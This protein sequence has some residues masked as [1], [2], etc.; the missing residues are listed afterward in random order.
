[1]TKS[2]I[3]IPS[4]TCYALLVSLESVIGKVG[5]TAVLRYAG[6][7]EFIDNYPPN[8]PD[9]TC[10]IADVSAIH[11]GIETLY[12]WRGGKALIMNAGRETWKKSIDAML[13]SP[14]KDI[15]EGIQQAPQEERLPRILNF[16]AR[17]FNPSND[18]KVE[19]VE[20]DDACIYVN[21]FCVCCWG[22]K[23]TKA[24]CHLTAGYLQEAVRWATGM[25]YPVDQ[26]TC[27]GCGDESCNYS[28]SKNLAS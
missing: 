27:A 15:L 26:I 25:V 12:G 10:D 5:L 18:G 28:F 21:R 6:L 14:A 1:M 4:N 8:I 7:A 23:M 17:L 9:R 20:T 16:V 19:V 22:R 2:N 11:A 24:G 13:A 3:F